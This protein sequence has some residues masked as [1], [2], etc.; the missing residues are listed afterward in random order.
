MPP[1]SDRARKLREDAAKLL[2]AAEQIERDG[3]E[4]L[5]EGHARYEGRPLYYGDLLVT[6]A[7]A[8]AQTYRPVPTSDGPNKGDLV[9]SHVATTTWG[10]RLHMPAIDIDVPCRYVPS[11]TPGHGHLYIDLL[12]EEELYFELLDVL[13][14]C[15]IV[16]PGYASASKAKGQSTLR[17]PWRKKTPEEASLRYDADQLLPASF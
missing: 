6:G 4:V 9:G 2:A 8:Q 7:E 10:E 1:I 14:R 3:A 17:P 15:G 16:E 11:T 12:V 5:G 13:A